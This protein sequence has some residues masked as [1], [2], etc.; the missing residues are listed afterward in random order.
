MATPARAKALSD[1]GTYA[2][3]TRALVSQIALGRYEWE[4]ARSSMP[5]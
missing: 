1:L 4:W 2:T 5:F 3:G